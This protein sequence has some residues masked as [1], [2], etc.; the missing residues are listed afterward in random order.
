[1]GSFGFP[2]IFHYPACGAEG[3][4]AGAAF[5]DPGVP[6]EDLE[7]GVH[8]LPQGREDGVVQEE[9]RLLRGQG[10]PVEGVGAETGVQTAHIGGAALGLDADIEVVFVGEG[11]FLQVELQLEAALQGLRPGGGLFPE[12]QGLEPGGKLTDPGFA[13]FLGQGQEGV[14][15]R[16]P[17]LPEEGGDPVGGGAELSAGRYARAGERLVFG[18]DVRRADGCAAGSRLSGRGSALSHGGADVC[19]GFIRGGSRAHC[20]RQAAGRAGL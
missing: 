4:V 16:A 1:M 11:G 5:P 6:S 8:Q 13:L 12:A 18:A 15:F 7:G 14:L 19:A 20:A 10:L 9:F 3:M 17:V 2:E